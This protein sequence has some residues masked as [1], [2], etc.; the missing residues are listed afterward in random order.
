MPFL[1]FEGLIS[2]PDRFKA[3]RIFAAMKTRMERWA[4]YRKKIQRTPEHKFRSHPHFERTSKE[5]ERSLLEK[6]SASSAVSLSSLPK[7]RL[8]PY[9]VYLARK[10]NA[11]I[12]KFVLLGIAIIGLVLLWF[13][14]VKR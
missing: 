4:R 6:G 3:V 7:K 9:G 2:F 12:G 14:W 13:L 1:S 8:T 11:L 5:E 10:R